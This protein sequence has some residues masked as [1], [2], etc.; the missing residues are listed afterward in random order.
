MATGGSVLHRAAS[1][2]DP[3]TSRLWTLVRPDQVDAQGDTQYT[4]SV[5]YEPDCRQFHP[6][7]PSTATLQRL[8][9]QLPRTRRSSH[10]LQQHS[11][12]AF[13]FGGISNC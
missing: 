3:T 11:F 2:T 13:G 5:V 10:H 4:V 8:C 7:P 12:S 6:R 9:A 1:L